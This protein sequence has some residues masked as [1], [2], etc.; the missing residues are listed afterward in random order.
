MAACGCEPGTGRRRATAWQKRH[1][2]DAGSGRM[3][4]CGRPVQDA[5]WQPAYP[6]ALSL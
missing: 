6:G 5:M 4:P 3:P 1:F 2:P